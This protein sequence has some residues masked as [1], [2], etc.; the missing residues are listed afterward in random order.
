MNYNNVNMKANCIHFKKTILLFAYSSIKEHFAIYRHDDRLIIYNRK[1]EEI[2]TFEIFLVSFIYSLCGNYLFFAQTN[3][4]I[5]KLNID[6]EEI[7]II[8][9]IENVKSMQYSPS[10][11]YLLFKTVDIFF[12]TIKILNLSDYTLSY[13]YS[14][15]KMSNFYIENLNDSF[16]YFFKK[17]NFTLFEK[18]D[19][20]YLP[21]NDSISLNVHQIDNNEVEYKDEGENIESDF[22]TKV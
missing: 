10:G 19:D 14:P 9:N 16:T 5:C 3:G 18:D 17:S 12:Y 2:K 7:E 1:G 4:N 8:T 22:L 21:A 11:K 6:T 13:I 20:V 15:S